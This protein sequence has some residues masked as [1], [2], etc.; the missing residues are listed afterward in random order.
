VRSVSILPSLTT[1]CRPSCWSRMKLIAPTLLALLS[2]A[3]AQD[4]EGVVVADENGDLSYQAFNGTVFHENDY[5]DKPMF[6]DTEDRTEGGGDG[7]IGG[8]PVTTET[9][10]PET[11][12]P[13]T[14]PPVTTNYNR[15]EPRGG[16]SR[17]SMACQRGHGGSA[18]G[19][20][21]LRGDSTTEQTESQE[22]LQSN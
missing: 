20:R 14:S 3:A 8:I 16:G 7:V 21:Y 1:T 22:V 11:S 5:Y 19:C 10:P 15:K 18:A 9:S 17:T 2:I 12:P 6:Q 4:P 13:E